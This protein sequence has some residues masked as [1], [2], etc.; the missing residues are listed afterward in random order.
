MSGSFVR[1][2][3]TT[4]VLV[5]AAGAGSVALLVVDR[6]NVTT[7]ESELR[8]KNIVPQW[9]LEDI[10]SVTLTARGKTARL[11]LGEPNASGQRLW[12]VELDGG[13]H[14]A[15]Q[16]TVDQLLG[17]LEY[18][19]FERRVSED[20]RG[21]GELGLAKP[22]TVVAIEMGPKTYRVA[23]GGT[24]PTPKDARYCE[25]GEGVFVITAQLAA[26]L[27]MR[28]ESLRSRVFVP[29]LSTELAALSVEGEGGARRF[30]RASWSGSRGAG[31]R[32]DGS[33]PE[34]EVR[35]DAEGFDRILGA[36]GSMQAE[37]FLADEEADKALQKR[38]TV[39]LVPSKARTENAV[40]EV[41]GACPGKDDQVV[42]VR[43]QPGRTSA[44]VPAG[45]IE[46][47][48]TPAK[49]FVDLALV[50][51]RFDEITEVA[52]TREG[53]TI[54]MARAGAGWHM[55]KP[56]DRKVSAD[57]GN[58]LVREIA[59]IEGTRVASGAPKDLGLEPPR[60]ILRVASS[61]PTLLTDAGPGERVETI[62]IGEPQGDVVHARRLEDGAIL[63]LPAEKL[64][65]L[66]PSETVL[67]DA[68]VLDVPPEQARTLA[69]T[70]VGASGARTQRLARGE[71]G[72]AFVE[73]KIADLAPDARL[74]SDVTDLLL[75]LRAVRWVAEKDDGS[76]GLDRPRFTLEVKVAEGEKDPGKTVRVEIGAATTDGSFAR[77][78]DDPAVFVAPRVLEEAAGLWLFD[79]GA[80]ALDASSLVRIEA[81]A[82]GGKKVAVERAGDT[83]KALTGEGAAL[84]ATLR[85]AASGLV[86][87]G[88]VSM[89]PPD[90]SFGL[91]KPRLVLT[92]VAEAAAGAPKGSVGRTVK[93][94]FGA[95]DSFHGTSVVYVRREGLDLTFA[96]PLG[97]VRALFEAAGVP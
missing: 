96:V 14:L 66:S 71:Q 83:W 65:A 26:A 94:S 91:D 61:L 56:A 40:I 12:D 4:I 74:V 38:V 97:R 92:V 45:V 80:L 21:E 89:G 78:G 17:T 35:A 20:A 27:D 52:L 9:R 79:R 67:R 77:L 68:Q 37:S 73:P 58:A 48:V 28:V 53:R 50:G 39:T 60:A 13:R 64:R 23:V 15:S 5:A 18:A 6:G 47:L 95:G 7:A 10:R 51:A 59:G 55:R 31:W 63:A 25:T 29:Y 30:K 85:D 62:E 87:E 54:E 22:E 84:A 19:T 93:L 70:A 88:V 69:V 1:R 49:D 41:G 8:K 81:A 44:C 57:A 32:F 76:F 2:H 75:K 43:R 90:R 42:A 82:E 3:L 16:Q 86:A 72:W 36:L 34:G 24:A 11:V 33:T 46:A